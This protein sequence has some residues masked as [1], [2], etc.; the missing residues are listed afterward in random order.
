VS[1]NFSN[2]AQLV[3]PVTPTASTTQTLC[4]GTVADLLIASTTGAFQVQS[5]EIV[6]IIKAEY[7]L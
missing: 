2:D 7:L 5:L 3:V 1:A 4:A 6:F